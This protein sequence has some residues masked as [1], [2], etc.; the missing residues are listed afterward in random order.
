MRKLDNAH[1]DDLVGVFRLNRPMG[2]QLV[3]WYEQGVPPL[4]FSP[5]FSLNK[6]MRREPVC[7][8]TRLPLH[9]Q[10]FFHEGGGNPCPPVF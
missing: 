7:A 10:W 4:G 3:V 9:F 6:G 2:L 8:G 1:V 5:A